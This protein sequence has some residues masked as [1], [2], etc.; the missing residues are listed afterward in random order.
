VL[1]RSASAAFIA[2][3]SEFAARTS[4][5]GAVNG[6]SQLAL[7]TL[8][9]G[10]PDFYQGTEYWDLSLVDPD[11]R[12]AVDFEWRRRELAD[13]PVH[14][15]ELATHWRNGRIKLAL[16]RQLLSLRHRFSDLFQRGSYEPVAITGPHAEHVVAFSRSWKRQRLVV[17]I[18]RHFAPLSDGG[19][20]WPSGWEGAIGQATAAY[21]SLIGGDPGART[22]DLT[23]AA[24]FRDLPVSV[25][26]QG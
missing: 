3:F 10:V 18:G 25:L 20:Q 12:R 2:S 23:V 1:D 15:S 22:T 11:N 8:L 7:K 16:T 14:W 17:A 4:L 6:L 21:E 19:R 26:R 13:S 9:P 5:L 24:L